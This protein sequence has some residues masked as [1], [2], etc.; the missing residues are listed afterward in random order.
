LRVGAWGEMSG[1]GR[2]ISE[3]GMCECTTDLAIVLSLLSVK[4]VPISVAHNGDRAF[5]TISAPSRINKFNS[6]WDIYL[7][8]HNLTRLLSA[9]PKTRPRFSSKRHA[10]VCISDA[11]EP[12][13]VIQFTPYQYN[14]TLHRFKKEDQCW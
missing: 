10:N 7:A 9:V 6:G 13:A 14:H 1:A 4:N 12:C 3:N 8:I 5:V 2:H 11:A